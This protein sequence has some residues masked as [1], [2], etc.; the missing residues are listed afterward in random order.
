MSLPTP[1]Q[2]ILQRQNFNC[3][4]QTILLDPLVII[5]IVNLSANLNPYT[6]Y[7]QRT[8]VSFPSN[9]VKSKENNTLQNQNN[10]KIIQNV[11][12]TKDGTQP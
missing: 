10:K 2:I 1:L 8:K 12:L 4:I 7:F 6:I 9:F 3:S 5:H 11:L